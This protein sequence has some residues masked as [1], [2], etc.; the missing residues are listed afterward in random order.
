MGGTQG[1]RRVFAK[2]MDGPVC[3]ET[4]EVVAGR[5]RVEGLDLDVG[6]GS[7]NVGGYQVGSVLKTKTRRGRE[8]IG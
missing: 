4:D 2:E 8:G 6:H 7:K 1:G 3:G 5:R